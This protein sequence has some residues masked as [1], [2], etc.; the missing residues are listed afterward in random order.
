MDLC[1]FYKK[2]YKSSL[3]VVY[4]QILFDK[5]KYVNS[6]K[7]AISSGS[8]VKWLLSK[9]NTYPAGWAQ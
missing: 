6:V 1:Y 3:Y 5:F 2:N 9:Y 4:Y 7:F 8:P